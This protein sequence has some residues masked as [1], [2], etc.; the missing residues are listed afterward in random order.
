LHTSSLAG[1]GQQSL[2][3][4]MKD[5]SKLCSERE[6]KARGSTLRDKDLLLFFAPAFYWSFRIIT[7]YDW[8]CEVQG[9]TSLNFDTSSNPSHFIGKETVLMREFA[10]THWSLSDQ[11]KNQKSS[12]GT[13]VLLYCLVVHT[14]EYLSIF[15]IKINYDHNDI[16]IYA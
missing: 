15:S 4:R 9:G 1:N 16:E 3:Q 7:N 14:I 8:L 5:Y 2:Y 11:T 13:L 10:L 6:E 12:S